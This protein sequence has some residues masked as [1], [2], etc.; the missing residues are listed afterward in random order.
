MII[1]DLQAKTCRVSESPLVENAKQGF[2]FSTVESEWA[3]FGHH[4]PIHITIRVSR[5]LQLIAHQPPPLIV[6]FRIVE[7]DGDT[8]PS[9]CRIASLF[10]DIG[11]EIKH[12]GEDFS[13]FW[14]EVHYDRTAVCPESK[15]CHCSRVAQR[16]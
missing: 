6:G 15:F 4:S 13:L 16:P 10:S 7:I 2:S 3:I 12:T 11:E 14:L 9:R 1:L 5:A 8:E